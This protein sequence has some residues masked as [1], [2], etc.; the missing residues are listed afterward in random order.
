ML[1]RIMWIRRASRGRLEVPASWSE[2]LGNEAVAAAVVL[3]ALESCVLGWVDVCVGGLG[4]GALEP[5]AGGVEMPFWS[6]SAM[7]D[8]MVGYEGCGRAV[9]CFFERG[10][11]MQVRLQ[12]N[13]EV[14]WFL[15][16]LCDRAAS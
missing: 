2:V 16:R 11:W 13:A 1:A 14:R 4:L 5:V 6:V 15:A 9:V 10:C 3:V 7:G 8:A 12:G